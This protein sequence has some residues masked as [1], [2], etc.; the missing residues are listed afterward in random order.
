MTLTVRSASLTG[1]TTAARALTHAEMDANWAHVIESSNQ[2]FTPSGSGATPGSVQDKLRALPIHPKV[3]FGVVGDG[4]TDDTTAFTNA[5]AAGSSQNRPIDVSNLT[6]KLTSAIT[7]TAGN[8]I[9]GNGTITHPKNASALKYDFALGTS[10]SVSA[11]GAATN[12]PALSGSLCTPLTV[13][14]A[15]GLSRND[16]CLLHST[17]TYAMDSATES[18][19]LLRILE[20]SGTTVYVHG[21]VRGSYSTSITLTKLS[22]EVLEIDGPS[23]ACNEDPY[24]A[25][26]DAGNSQVEV[27]GAVSPIIKATFRDNTTAGLRL[28]S[29]W[30]P[31]VDVIARNLRDK[32]ANNMLGYAV[33]V[34]GATAHGRYRIN[35]ERVRHAWTNGLFGASS[36]KRYGGAARYN[37]VSGEAVNTTG[38]A[39]DTH[40]GAF[41]TTFLN[42]TADWNNQD[43]DAASG[44][45]VLG[46]QDRG[47]GTRYF[48]CHDYGLGFGWYLAGNLADH[49]ETNITELH[50]CTSRN[51]SGAAVAPGI[52]IDAKTSSDTTIVRVYN[53]V[54]RDNTFGSFA[55]ACGQFEF[56]DCVF[57]SCATFRL[58]RDNTVKMFGCRRLNPGESNVEPISIDEGT[59]LVIDDYFAEA[60]SFGSSCLLR[61]GSTAGTATVYLG[62][63][64]SSPATGAA[65]ITEN[66]ATLS[67][68][69]MDKGGRVSADR[70]DAAATLQAGVDPETNVWATAL[71]EARGVS[72]HGTAWNGA[73]FRVVRTAASTGAFNLNVGTG[74]LAALAV[75]EWCVVEF[76]GSAWFLTGYGALS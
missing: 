14:S 46:F 73:R 35:A 19:E 9:I 18:A 45:Q 65:P 48:N 13:S 21:V 61:T 3:D 4:T 37:K 75:G 12:F 47:C 28:V 40:A 42:C 50:G 66:T 64:S 24:S 29:C 11:I 17:D 33:V 49:D 63:L 52:K 57:H 62:K 27:I 7:R 32:S 72:L 26:G 23:F 5:L 34:Y 60:T 8:R 43:G 76:D 39:W 38:N 68:V 55:Q 56:Y 41:D 16:V 71:T 20:I 2:N 54:F 69:P 10:T 53:S 31:K 59:T 51:A 74:P 36:D 15:S 67:L 30:M 6:I 70:G 22:T 25:T 1:A 58:G 44:G